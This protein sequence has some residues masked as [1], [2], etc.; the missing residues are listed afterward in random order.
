MVGPPLAVDADSRGA[1]PRPGRRHAGGG[2][3]SAGREGA[4]R[5]ARAAEPR[6]LQRRRPRSRGRPRPAPSPRLLPAAATGA[7]WPGFR[8]PAR[9]GVVPGVRIATDW[10]A[11]AAGRA[12]AP[13]DRTGL[14]VVRGPRRPRLH[15]GAA[16]RRRGRLLLQADDRRARLETRATRPGSGSR[17]PAPVRAGRRPSTTAASTHSG[18]TGHPERARRRDRRGRVVAQRGRRHRASRSRPGASPA[19]PWWWAT[20]SSSPPPA[21]S[22]PTTPPPA[23]RAGSA[24]RAAGATARRTW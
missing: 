2:R 7:D 19:R 6:P 20:S 23:S 15:P 10:V 24:R 5:D 12:V 8:G 4:R 11:V 3:S 13:A 9:D 18:A 22:P 16:R 1:A 14:V 17:M 21:G